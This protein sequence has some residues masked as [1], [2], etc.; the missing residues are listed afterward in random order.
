MRQFLSA[1]FI[2]VALPAEADDWLVLKGEEIRDTLSDRTVDYE[3]AWQDFRADSRT[4]YNAGAD[5]W[6][7]WDIRNNQY[8]SQWPPNSAWTCYDVDL[9]ADGTAARFRGTGEDIS[10]GMFRGLN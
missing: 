8:C 1:L 7:N 3:A 5:S 4:L 2:L 9:N 10:V 6:G